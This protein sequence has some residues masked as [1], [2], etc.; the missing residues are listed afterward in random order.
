MMKS[1]LSKAIADLRDLLP[2]I[3]QLHGQLERLGQAML[4]CWEKRGKVLIAGNGGSAADAMHLAEELTVRFAKNRR[5]LAAMALCDPTVLTCA[6]ND[7]GYDFVFARQ[8]EA[9]GNPGDVFIALTT[10]GNSPNIIKAVD[11]AKA[12][13]LT[14]AAFLGKDGGA[15]HGKC[16]IELLIPFPTTARIQEA[17]KVL[18]HTLCEWIESKVD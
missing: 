5:A 4:S 18:Y 1:M 14:T 17:H 16:D 15:L 3:E 12:R 11:L 8:I 10:S 7:L 6:A 13:K 9:F 2:R